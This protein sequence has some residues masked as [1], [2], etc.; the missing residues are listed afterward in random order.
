MKCAAVN[1]KEQEQKIIYNLI[2]YREKKKLKTI[3]RY[4]GICI[5]K[6]NPKHGVKKVT[7]LGDAGTIN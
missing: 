4:C 1:R 7:L 6:Y 2:L 5:N 3:T